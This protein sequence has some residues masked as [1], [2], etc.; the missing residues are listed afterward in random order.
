MHNPV[1]ILLLFL[2]ITVSSTSIAN[3]ADF[4]LIK[5]AIRQHEY[6]KAHTLLLPLAQSN[7]SD[8]QL[9]LGNFYMNGLIANK[10]HQQAFEWFAKAAKLNNSKAQYHLG[11]MYDRGWGVTKDTQKAKNW[12]IKSAA[13]G[14]RMAKKKLSKLA[15]EASGAH[16][17]TSDPGQLCDIFREAVTKNNLKTIQLAINKKVNINCLDQ[18]QRTALMDAIDLEKLPAIEFLIKNKASIHVKDSFGDTPLHQAINRKNATIVNALLKRGADTKTTDKN[19]NSALHKAIL[20]NQ[21]PVVSLLIKYHADVNATNKKGETALD[22]AIS[23]RLNHLSKLLKSKGGVQKST[24]KKKNSVSLATLIKP[25]DKT[26]PVYN[27]WTPLMVTIWRNQ[28]SATQKILDSKTPQINYSSKDGNTALLLAIKKEQE[29][30]AIQLVSKGSKLTP[31]KQ[32]ESPLLL[33]A[34]FGFSKFIQHISW[35]KQDL[36]LR[37]NSG[38]TPLIL[39]VKNKKSSAIKALLAIGVDP[40]LTNKFGENALHIASKFKQVN[41]LKTLLKTNININ[42]QTNNKRTALW[43]AIS[44]QWKGGFELLL[45]N[46]P[47][48]QLKDSLGLSSLAL[49]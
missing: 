30:L 42:T 24:L 38:D 31:N 49:A 26:N 17:K 48:T 25:A 43:Y 32:N 39:A 1:N 28:T 6:K 18:H 7:N 44:N 13:N 20:V 16:I 14:Y 27:D 29:D 35:K 46:K 37:N 22:I 15:K 41:T 47:N 23:H 3:D 12:F 36:N 9:M 11:T 34:T 10:N 5:Q 19:G 2:C 4:V 33:A 45:K 40:T 21:Q 8:A